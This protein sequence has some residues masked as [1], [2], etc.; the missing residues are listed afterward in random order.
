MLYGYITM[1]GQQ[2]IKSGGPVF[3][4]SRC[5]PQDG[6]PVSKRVTIDTYHKLYLMIDGS[7]PTNAL[8]VNLPHH[9]Q[10]TK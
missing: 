6:T 3:L 10:P 2:N 5:L 4:R 7:L 1:H 9:N 8:D